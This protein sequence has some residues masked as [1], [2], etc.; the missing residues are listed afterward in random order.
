MDRNNFYNYLIEAIAGEFYHVSD[1]DLDGKTLHPRT[2]SNKLVA[3]GHEDGSTNR[4]CVGPTIGHCLRGLAR[5]LKDNE[6]YVHV[7]DHGSTFHQ[8]H[9][10]Q[11]PDVDVTKEHW[12]I[13]PVKLRKIGKIKVTTGKDPKQYSIG[14]TRNTSYGWNYNWIK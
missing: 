7:V 10:G 11:V 3:A 6:L 2:P 13:E 14:D 12:S 4:V 9:T 5:G 1:Q 8:P